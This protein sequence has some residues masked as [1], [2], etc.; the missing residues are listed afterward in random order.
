MAERLAERWT[1]LVGRSFALLAALLLLLF[2]SPLAAQEN[3]EDAQAEQEAGADE[4]ASADDEASTSDDA[5][6]KSSDDEPDEEAQAERLALADAALIEKER[7]LI[8]TLLEEIASPGY[9][10]ELRRGLLLRVLQLNLTIARETGRN[11]AILAFQTEHPDAP[12]AQSTAEDEPEDPEAAEAAEIERKRREAEAAEERALDALRVAQELEAR[13]H[14]ETLKRL[15]ARQR[16]AA[17]E[18]LALTRSHRDRMKSLREDAKENAREFAAKRGEF[19]AK[20]DTFPP[21]PELKEREEEVDPLFAELI[22]ERRQTRRDFRDAIARRE[23]AEQDLSQ[24][25]RRLAQQRARLNEVESA[26]QDGVLTEIQERRTEAARAE[27][28]VADAGQKAAQEFL[29]ERQKQYREIERRLAFLRV[30]TPKLLEKISPQA[31]R[32]FFTFSDENL[33]YALA[34]VQEGAQYLLQHF[35]T[36]ILENARIDLKSLDLWRWLWGLFWRLLLVLIAMRMGAPHLTSALERRNRAILERQF[37]RERALTTLKLTDTF[38]TLARPLMIYLAARFLLQY[39]ISEELIASFSAMAL[40]GWAINAVFLYWMVIRVVQVF[41]LPR[42]HRRPEVE[43]NFGLG[44]MMLA[45]RAPAEPE[46]D[47]GLIRGKK[48]VRSARV[49]LF[50][51]LLATYVPDAVRLIIGVSIFSWVIDFVAVW[52]FLFIFYW[53]LS[54]WK[55]DIAQVFERLAGGRMP[56]AVEVVN[57]RKDQFYGV[58]IIAAASVYVLGRETVRVGRKYLLNTEW[59]RQINTLLFRAKIELRNRDE[60]ADPGD[61]QLLSLPPE[62]L[63]AFGSP[64]DNTLMGTFEAQKDDTRFE[65]FQ[66]YEELVAIYRQWLKAPTEGAA[67]IAGEPGAGK[68]ALVHQFIEH[69]GGEPP[70]KPSGKLADSPTEASHAK[71]ERT[72]PVISLQFQERVWTQRAIVEKL[73]DLFELDLPADA[74]LAELIRQIHAL[75]PRVVILDDCYH[76]FIR[77]IGGFAAIKALF[78]V[79]NSTDRRH[80]YLLTFN[81]FSWV[82]INRA[83]A[84]RPFLGE[85]I[86]M[87]PWTD[88]ELQTLMEARTRRSGYQISFKEL[89]RTRDPSADLENKAALQDTARGYFRYLQEFSGG[90]PR[91]AMRY[92]L[93][94][95]R[96]GAD[97]KTL[98]VNLFRRP[99]TNSF[100]GFSDDYWFVL[101]AIAQHGSLSSPELAQTMHLDVRFCEQALRY[102]SD[103]GVLVVDPGTRKATFTPLYYRQVL[104]HLEHSNFLDVS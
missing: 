38:E 76:V 4:E 104:R 15:L 83:M 70:R 45:T 27:F 61:T 80:F 78:D 77:K 32:Q 58:F 96:L 82:Y 64:A 39:L 91:V 98:H 47:P 48:L 89:L 23:A 51:A 79:V 8:E 54:T 36:E 30:E 18:M 9:P 16:E 56:R 37:F 7:A 35:E 85:V 88:V 40:P 63:A 46:K 100:A 69:V 66:E 19:S 42:W 95:L 87:D 97:K 17:E 10:E 34:G 102:F 12:P 13:E 94:S 25:N 2:A 49:V 26:N 101:A 73:S 20:I 50:F 103:L 28:A 21:V 72:L 31:R 24:A 14:D 92:W 81:L 11:E 29:E 6:E 84:R 62:Y 68:S 71:F 93:R 60:D 99:P 1:R 43:D 86:E 5:Q 59:Y 53:V 57:T 33:D 44:P 55:D 74:D 65:R 75:E 22:R 52:G 90:N 41:A 67:V 3:S